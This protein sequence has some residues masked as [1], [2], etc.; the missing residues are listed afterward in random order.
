[1]TVDKVKEDKERIEK[2]KIAGKDYEAKVESYMLKVKAGG[3]E[4][5][6]RLKVWHVKEFAVPMARMELAADFPESAGP[7][8]AASVTQRLEVQMELLETG[9]RPIEKKEDKKDAKDP[10]KE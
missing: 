6:A 4:F 1:M 7:A 8:G 2:I 9:N 10:K 5:P 3:M